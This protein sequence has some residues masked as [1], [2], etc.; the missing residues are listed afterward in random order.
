M[1]DGWHD[2]LRHKNPPR[3]RAQTIWEDH[4]TLQTSLKT[5]LAGSALAAVLATGAQAQE[6]RGVHNFH[7]A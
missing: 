5:F 6:L 4:M 1:E 7:Q 3:K 2:K